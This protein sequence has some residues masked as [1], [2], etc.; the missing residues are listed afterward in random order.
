MFKKFLL[1]FC[2]VTAA[3]SLWTYDPGPCGLPTRYRSVEAERAFKILLVAEGCVL[4]VGL[5]ARG[6]P[7]F[8]IKLSS[9][10]SEDSTR[11]GVWYPLY[12]VL[13]VLWIAAVSLAGAFLW[14][15]RV[16]RR[17]T[18]TPPDSHFLRPKA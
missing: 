2:L 16:R 15:L 10:F 8:H 3:V 5:V 9:T 12:L 13:N 4:D 6:I 7:A 11:T 18:A 14:N 17:P 1:L